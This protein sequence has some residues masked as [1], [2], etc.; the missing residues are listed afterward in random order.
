MEG[1]GMGTV[2][3]IRRCAFCVERAEGNF[4]IHRDGFGEGPEVDLCDEHGSRPKPTCEEIWDRI[5]QEP[6]K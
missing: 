2:I 5:G 4:S 1:E 3:P 6:A